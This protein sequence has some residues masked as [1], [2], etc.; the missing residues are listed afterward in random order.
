MEL[1]EPVTLL[2]EPPIVRDVAA[3]YIRQKL[4][5][6]GDGGDAV[7]LAMA[8]VHQ[9]DFLLTWNCQHLA[10]AN[11]VRHLGVLNARLG[12]AVPVLATPLTLVPGDS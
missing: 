12:L 2:D 11:K 7:H 6:K 9:C 10:N 3:F 4:M 1:L 8:S 5:P